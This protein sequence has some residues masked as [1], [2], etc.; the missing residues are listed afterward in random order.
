MICPLKN[1][2]LRLELLGCPARAV[3]GTRGYFAPGTPKRFFQVEP[4][5][6]TEIA[7]WSPRMSS[8]PYSS[9]LKHLGFPAVS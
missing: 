3:S 6:V 2:T 1:K 7:E 8:R 9:N 5:I 4:A